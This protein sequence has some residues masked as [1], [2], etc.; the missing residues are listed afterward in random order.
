MLN[1]LVEKIQ[2]TATDDI[3]VVLLGYESEM[4]EMFRQQN[5]GLKR[6]FQNNPF[7]FEDFNEDDLLKIFQNSCQEHDVIAPVPV[8]RSA[9]RVRREM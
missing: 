3:A 4:N 2:G 7:I 6:R 5:P 1:T 9:L 8:V